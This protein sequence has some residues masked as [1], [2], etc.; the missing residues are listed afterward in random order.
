[1]IKGDCLIND[2]FGFKRSILSVV[3]DVLVD[4]EA[5]MVT[6]S[7]TRFADPTH[8]FIDTHRGKAYVRS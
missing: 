6:S 4:N 1:M 7:I 3:G 5:P 2:S 8:F